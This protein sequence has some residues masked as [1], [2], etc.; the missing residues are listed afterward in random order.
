MTTNGFCILTTDDFGDV[1]FST[2]ETQE[3]AIGHCFDD[4]IL[5]KGFTRVD[6]AYVKAL[7]NE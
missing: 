7:R 1:E 4:A 6:D 3:P 2:E 5:P